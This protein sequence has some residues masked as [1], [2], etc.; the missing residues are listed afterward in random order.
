MSASYVPSAPERDLIVKIQKR[1]GECQGK[2][3]QFVD[4]YE[5]NERAYQGVLERSSEAAK[6][7]HQVHPAYAFNLVETIVSSSTEQG[8]RLDVR[9]SPYTNIPLDEA[10]KM[11]DKVE[12][13]N[14]LLAHEHRLDGMPWKQRPLF[15]TSA[16]GGRG[17]LATYWNYTERSVRRQGVEEKE[18]RGPNDELLGTV[19]TVVEIVEDGVLRDHSTSEVIDPR[20]FIVHPGARSLQPFDPGGAQYLFNRVFWSIEQM[21]MLERAGFLKNVDYVTESRNYSGD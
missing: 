3:Q 6:W 14:D 5:K 9:P 19:P 21:K 18:V 20:D 4:M 10:I 2:H 15:L 7:K 12:S 13:V 11:L 8:L 17:V 16:I 1:W